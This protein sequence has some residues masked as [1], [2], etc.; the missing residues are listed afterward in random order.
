MNKREVVRSDH[1]FEI[2]KKKEGGITVSDTGITISRRQKPVKKD[3]DRTGSAYLLIDC[4]AS[5]AGSKI[6]QALSGALGFA[7]DAIKKGYS[8]GV[9]TFGWKA[10][11]LCKP[12]SNMGKLSLSLILPLLEIGG[13]TNIAGA[14]SLG[15]QS[16]QDEEGLKA[17]VLITDGMP[18]IGKPDAQTATINEARKARN[19]GIDILTIGTDDAELAFLERIT[20]R[21][22]LAFHVPKE[23]LSEAIKSS[24]QLLPGP[25][26]VIRKP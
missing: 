7:Q 15:A 9:I 12:T 21:T 23:N 1:G 16:L 25:K 17:L 26:N 4:S 20:T 19:A 8:T 24:A 14:I 18:N 10:F 3:M 11:R 6:Q 2:T 13:G 5:M 22:N